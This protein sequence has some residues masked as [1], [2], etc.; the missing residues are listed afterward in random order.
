[1]TT[2]VKT[3]WNSDFK[4]KKRKKKSP[5]LARIKRPLAYFSHFMTVII[6]SPILLATL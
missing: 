4:K 1:M 5:Y 3:D 6:L 2:V